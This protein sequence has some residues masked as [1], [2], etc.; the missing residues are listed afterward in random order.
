MSRSLRAGLPAQLGIGA[1]VNAN[2]NVCIQYCLARTLNGQPQNQEQETEG[3]LAEPV[4]AHIC[5]R[6]RNGGPC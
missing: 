3:T 5:H 1:H 4:V 6:V 2:V